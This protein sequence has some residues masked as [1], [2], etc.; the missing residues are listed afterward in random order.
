MALL[1]GNSKDIIHG[2]LKGVNILDDDGE[3]ALLSDFGLSRVKADVNSG[4]TG[5]S[6]VVVGSPHCTAPE[7]E[8]FNLKGE[9]LQDA[10]IHIHNITITDHK[11]IQ[12][13]I[14]RGHWSGQIVSFVFS[15]STPRQCF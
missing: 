3:N 6:A 12:R 11:L 2:D 15:H 7:R 5:N 13:R 9:I 8:P 10:N 14:S 1:V 4:S